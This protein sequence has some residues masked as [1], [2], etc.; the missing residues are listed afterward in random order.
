MSKGSTASGGVGFFGLLGIVFIVLK[1]CKVIDW[2]WLWV[3]API[4]GPLAL[5]AFILF[6]W[7]LIAVCVYIAR[8]MESPEKRKKRLAREHR[9]AVWRSHFGRFG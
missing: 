1:L 6:L 3:L 4:W 8:T 9:E 5:V 7:G 2:D